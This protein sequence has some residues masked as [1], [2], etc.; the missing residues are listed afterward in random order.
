M[1]MS[2]NNR[3]IRND[4][5]HSGKIQIPV[6]DIAQQAMMRQIQEQ[7]LVQQQAMIEQR[8][9]DQLYSLAIKIF[10]DRFEGNI[11]H[12][13]NQVVKEDFRRS[14]EIA[15]ILQEE[16]NKHYSEKK[17]GPTGGQS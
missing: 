3:P 1:K 9:A 4:K 17:K 14:I 7:Q 5:I 15:E 8:Q 12:I 6:P 2:Q 16:V 13:A 10:I 11:F